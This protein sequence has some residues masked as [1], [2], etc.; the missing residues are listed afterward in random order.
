MW[1]HLRAVSIYCVPSSYTVQWSVPTRSDLH[2]D[3]AQLPGGQ[4]QHQLYQEM[5]TVQISWSH[6]ICTDKV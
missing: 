3:A 2:W 4:D 1:T 5:E 6:P